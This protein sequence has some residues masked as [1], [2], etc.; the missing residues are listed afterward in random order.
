VGRF[1]GSERVRSLRYAFTRLRHVLANVLN[2]YVFRDPRYLVRVYEDVRGRFVG[3]KMVCPQWRA[4]GA[5]WVDRNYWVRSGRVYKERKCSYCG[6][7]HPA[8]FMRHVAKVI[9]TDGRAGYEVSLADNRIKIYIERP[10]ARNVDDGPIKFK[11]Y[12][13]DERTAQDDLKLINRALQI[14]RWVFQE[15]MSEPYKERA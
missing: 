5:R 3:E 11:T 7:Q 6:S 12:H 1:G 2:G 13:L 9:E 4:D 14:S 10:G 15:R 8:D